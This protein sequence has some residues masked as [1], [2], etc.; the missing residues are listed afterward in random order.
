VLLVIL[1]IAW[2]AVSLAS[3]AF[4]MT[5]APL[6]RGCLAAA[7]VAVPGLQLGALIAFA[8]WIERAYA[9][10]SHIS[11]EPTLRPVVAAA[12]FMIPILNLILP[13]TV[14][15]DIHRGEPETSEGRT[16]MA[17]P[18]VHGLWWL[19]FTT[20]MGLSGYI[21]FAIA[22]FG[23]QVIPSI[24]GLAGAGALVAW[25]GQRLVFSIDRAQV[26]S[27]DLRCKDEQK[28]AGV[29]H[30]SPVTASGWQSVAL[31]LL[32]LAETEMQRDALPPNPSPLAR[33]TSDSPLS[34][35][36]HTRPAERRIGQVG[37]TARP[38]RTLESR[39]SQA[40]VAVQHHAS[41][42][43]RAAVASAGAIPQTVAVKTLLILTATL[44]IIQILFFALERS[45]PSLP[46]FFSRRDL[47]FAQGLVLLL[48][49]IAF[50]EWTARS[51]RIAS[52]FGTTR[53][54]QADVIPQMIGSTGGAAVLD[55][56]FM[57]TFSDREID[58]RP[59]DRWART[60]RIFKWIFVLFAVAL[61]FPS[62][63]PL[64]TTLGLASNVSLLVASGFAF[65][66][67]QLISDVQRR[68]LRGSAPGTGRT[69]ETSRQALRPR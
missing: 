67:C 21:P 38:Q 27:F 33:T 28:P 15:R 51:Y 36:V 40:G 30:E 42:A 54:V 46:L 65:H 43:R 7:L 62:G 44:S 11:S 14:F 55:D 53:F 10:L 2:V 59:L 19:M 23:E 50:L 49:I 66:L 1:A 34:E 5:A 69:G 17:R 60:W 3:V 6:W 64:R 20:I 57:L 52:R 9:N 48:T 18:I 26:S 61:L 22:E 37:E 13:W 24:G 63:T 41:T 47:F 32:T 29:T 16:P 68:R 56:L 4:P 35:S 45:V 12:S 25:G 31:P 39:L 58:P 8:I